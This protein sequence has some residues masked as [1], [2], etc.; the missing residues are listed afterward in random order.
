MTRQ[1]PDRG[2]LAVRQRPAPHRP[3]RRL[4]RALRRLQPLQRMAGNDVL[5]VSG[6]D[7]HGTPIL[8]QADKEGVTPR[9]LADRYNRVIVEDLQRR[10]ACPT[11]CSPARRRATTTPSCRSCS[12]RCTATAT[13]SQK[14]T[15]RR[16]LAVDRAHPARPLHRGHLPDLRLRRRARRPVRQ[17]RQPARPDRPDRPA[18][19]DQRRDAEVRRDRALLP[20]PAGA[21]P[22]RSASWLQTR[23]DWRP[24]VLKF[25]PEPA[26]RPPAAGHHPRP[27]LG[28]ADPARRL[29]GPRR[30]ADLRVVRRGH[31]LPVGVGRVGPAHRRPRRLARVV[32]GPG[33]PA[34]YYFM[35][36]DNIVFH[37]RDLAGDPAR[38]QRQGRRGGEPGALGELRPADRGR[39]QRVPHHGGPQVL[40]VAVGRHLRPRLPRALRRRRAALLHRR[41]RPGEPG[42][43]LHLGGVRAPQQR[44]AGR[45]L[46]QPGQPHRLDGREERR[47][48][49]GRRR[50]DRRRPRR[51]STPAAA[52]FATVGGAARALAAEGRDRRGDAGGRRGEQVPLRPGAVEAQGPDPARMATVLHVALQAVDDCKTLLSPFLP[53][54]AQ[55][56]HELLGGDGRLVAACRRSREVDDLDGGPDYPVITGD[57]ADAAAAG[58]PRRSCPARRVAAADAGVHASSTRRSSRRSWPGSRATACGPPR[59]PPAALAPC[60]VAG[61]PL[62]LDVAAERRHDDLVGSPV[63]PTRSAARRRRSGCTGSCRSAATCR[64]ARW[65]VGRWPRDPRAA[66]RRRAAPQRGAAA[67][68]PGA[69]D[70]AA[71]PRSTRWPRTRGC[72]RSARRAWTTSAPARTARGAGG[73]VPPAHRD[74]QGAGKA[75]QSST[76][77]TPIL[78][79]GTHPTT[80]E[81]IGAGEAWAR[82]H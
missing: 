48:D 24:N 73:L 37:S 25:S 41:G 75:L 30:Q 77:A 42:H 32:A 52:A 12:G 70:E 20:R 44:R 60:P 21:S 76:T 39:L 29:G 15:H 71:W 58:R 65:S 50:A 26:R 22:R 4:R 9:E 6:T 18:Q 69:L 7:E 8:V 14:T 2:R 49:P 59:E 79:F 64:A 51:C 74:G 35:G 5:M 11:T 38:L 72:G 40:L 19:P 67:R 34:S 82:K 17:L 33:R 13:S 57:Y 66:R 55:T 46:G 63:E 31:R 27:R 23:T 3:R 81:R 16:D 43:R 53:H 78:L 36:K 10:S 56:V 62:P 61:Q 80:V 68:R 1:H 54:S 28:R 47:R 45:R